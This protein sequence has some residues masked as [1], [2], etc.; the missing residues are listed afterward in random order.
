M[1]NTI[2][3]ILVLVIMGVASGAMLTSVYN[4]ASPLI[5]E[6]EKKE[7][8]EAI[9]GKVL[10]EA[11]SYNE[12]IKDG[13]LIYEGIDEEGKVVGYAFTGEGN[14]YQG[15][16]KLIAGLDVRLEKLTGI[17]VL[18]SSETPGLG[19]KIT[20][21]VFK[22]QFRRLSISPEI[23]FTK[24]KVLKNNEIQAITGATIS[25][26]SIVGILNNE[27]TRVRAAIKK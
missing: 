8:I 7:K 13:V 5:E 24:N 14:G 1:K 11:T 23:T 27:I 22:S 21:E 18:E 10:P 6:N 20:E 4:Y 16:I 26:R 12:V 19:A 25:T 3:M 17:E 9:T 15:K 2:R